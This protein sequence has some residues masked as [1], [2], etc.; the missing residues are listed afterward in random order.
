MFGVLWNI[1]YLPSSLQTKKLINL[2]KSEFHMCLAFYGMLFI[3]NH[4]HKQT[5]AIVPFATLTFEL[6][7][8]KITFPDTRLGSSDPTLHNLALLTW[9]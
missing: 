4:H 8:H 5:N 1:T 2:N 9:Y 3:Y 7:S 6:R